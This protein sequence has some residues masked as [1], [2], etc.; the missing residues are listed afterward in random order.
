MATPQLQRTYVLLRPNSRA[1]IRGNDQHRRH[2]RV[3]FEQP[4][5]ERQKLEGLTES[6]VIGKY[7]ATDLIVGLEAV[8]MLHPSEASPLV[9]QQ[10]ILRSDTLRKSRFRRYG[11]Q[12]FPT[13][14]LILECL[15]VGSEHK[16]LSAPNMFFAGRWYCSGSNGFPVSRLAKTF[17]NVATTCLASSTE[18]GSGSQDTFNLE[19]PSVSA[20]RTSSL[21]FS[22]AGL[23][24][25]M[26]IGS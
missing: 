18:I 12:R 15:D 20:D 11:L 19:L 17:S 6:H 9:W 10:R 5:H 1:T 25:G 4:S 21:S 3:T 22:M 23:L 24:V 16:L 8:Q 2:I 14:L 26:A 7:C 13:H